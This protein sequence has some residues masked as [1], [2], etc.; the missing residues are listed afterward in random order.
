MKYVLIALIAASVAG[1]VPDT[2]ATLETNTNIT[3]DYCRSVNSN[4]WTAICTELNSADFK[5]TIA[6]VSSVKTK[7]LKDLSITF[8]NDTDSA[9]YKL[10]KSIDCGVYRNIRTYIYLRGRGH[11]KAYC[12]DT[13]KYMNY[14]LKSK[15]KSPVLRAFAAKKPPVPV[16]WLKKRVNKPGY[17]DIVYYLIDGEICLPYHVQFNKDGSVKQISLFD[18]IDAKDA[19]PKYRDLMDR[20]DKKIYAEMKATGRYGKLGSVHWYWGRKREL[21]KQQG[22]KWRSPRELNPQILYD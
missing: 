12:Y 5:S 8:T 9:T 16:T 13:L 1:I 2:M 17:K 4:S 14:D 22:I 19:D 20:I 15:I 3:V 7:D 11:T 21:L 10:S 6:G 18:I